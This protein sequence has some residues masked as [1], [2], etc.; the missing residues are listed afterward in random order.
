MLLINSSATVPG[1]NFA[2]ESSI[3]RADKIA[4]VKSKRAGGTLVSK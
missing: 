1:T 4:G 3:P 2:K